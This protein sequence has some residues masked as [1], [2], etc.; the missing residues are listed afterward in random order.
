MCGVI[1]ERRTEN[2]LCQ[3]MIKERQRSEGRTPER[4]IIIVDVKIYP[5]GL[6]SGMIAAGATCFAGAERRVSQNN[7]KHRD[8]A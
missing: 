1:A 5:A 8:V 4:S 3:S 7:T 2:W 6:H